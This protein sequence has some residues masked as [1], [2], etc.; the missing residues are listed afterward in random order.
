MCMLNGSLQNALYIPTE[1]LLN[2]LMI[3]YQL[4]GPGESH[5]YRLTSMS[6]EKCS[7]Y[8]DRM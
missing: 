5:Q 4:L 6:K 7:S 3:S 8:T 2:D 1:E